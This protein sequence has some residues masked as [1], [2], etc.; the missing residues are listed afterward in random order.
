MNRNKRESAILLLSCPDRRGIVAE[1]SRFINVYDGSVLHSDQ[2]LDSD[3]NIFFLRTEWDLDG[4]TLPKESIYGAFEPIARKFEMEWNLIFTPKRSRL[5][6][7]VSK[8]DHC[9]YELL[10]RCKSGEINSEVTVIIGNHDRCRAIADYFEV[11]FHLIEVTSDNKEEAEERQFAILDERKVDLIVLARYMQILSSR[12]VERY[13]WRIINI[14]HSFL[15]AFV[16][17]R[18]YHQAHER[19]VKIIGATSH[20]VTEELDQ[21]PIIEQDVTRISHRDA[22]RD[23]IEKGRHLERQVLA[24]AVKLHTEHK[25]LVFNN[26]TVIFD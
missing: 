21:G 16:G 24:Q 25:L 19:G 9:L 22:P 17:A 20:Y 26:K 8:V 12:F 7:M 23:L 10:L 4:F 11:P 18:P 5:A 3:S 14:H 1:V 13:P 2:H 15:P 6:L